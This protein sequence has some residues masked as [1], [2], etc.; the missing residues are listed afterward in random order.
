MKKLQLEIK[1]KNK[2]NSFNNISIDDSINDHLWAEKSAINQRKSVAVQRNK[3]DREDPDVYI[4][5]AFGKNFEFSEKYLT[6]NI[7]PEVIVKALKKRY[8]FTKITKATLKHV[9]YEGARLNRILRINDSWYEKMVEILDI[10]LD[11]DEEELRR[12]E[13]LKEEEKASTTHLPPVK[14]IFCL[15]LVLKLYL[16]FIWFCILK[17]HY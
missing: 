12:N 1:C 5:K 8:G 10:P 2:N 6:S 11:K 13:E 3:I 9:L 15:A 16:F 4:K 17:A 7:K 14:F